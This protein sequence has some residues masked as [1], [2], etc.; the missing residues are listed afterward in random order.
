MK[1]HRCSEMGSF[2]VACLTW[3][4]KEAG[5]V[6]GGCASSGLLLEAV[7]GSIDVGVIDVGM[8]VDRSGM[9]SAVDSGCAGGPICS[10]PDGGAMEALFAWTVQYV[11]PATT[12]RPMI[13]S[14][15]RMMMHGARPSPSMRV[16]DA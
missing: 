3:I 11:A 5:G 14:V 15:E 16:A 9:G 13:T 12:S 8:D 2:V 7:D 1:R 6:F 4:T 10:G